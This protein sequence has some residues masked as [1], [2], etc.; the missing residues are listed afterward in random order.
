MGDSDGTSGEDPTLAQAGPE[1]AEPTHGR[2]PSGAED[3][4]ASEHGAALDHVP[5]PGPSP[6]LD[7]SVQRI[8]H[9]RILRK[10]GEGGMGVVYEAHDEKLDRR[11]AIKL[12]RTRGERRE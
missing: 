6:Q 2:T 11:V 12:L 9:Y 5:D 10:L 1:R 4:I 3:T 8:H 7:P